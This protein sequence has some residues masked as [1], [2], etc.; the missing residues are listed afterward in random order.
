[1]KERAAGLYRLSA[2]Y[3]STLV[4]DMVH[5][6]TLPLLEI[7]M[8]YWLTGMQPYAANYFAFLA[9]VVLENIAVDVRTRV[10]RMRYHL[11]SF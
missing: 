4:T 2:Y 3:L 7:T 1:M 5:V 9:I 11:R 6:G 10:C 8:V